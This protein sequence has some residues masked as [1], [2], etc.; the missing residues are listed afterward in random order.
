[1]KIN[2]ILNKTILTL[3]FK[4]NLKFKTQTI[5]IFLILIDLTLSKKYN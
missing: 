1:M 5:K 4:H 2:K 3:Y